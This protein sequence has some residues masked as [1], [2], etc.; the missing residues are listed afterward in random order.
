MT[1]EKS[2]RNQKIYR[3]FIEGGLTYEE[4]SHKYSLSVWTIYPILKRVRT[5]LTVKAILDA[6]A[7]KKKQKHG[8]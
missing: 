4:L 1:Q 2:R 8:Q 3:D 5:S 7:L 6:E